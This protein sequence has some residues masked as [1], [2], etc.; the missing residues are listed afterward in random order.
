MGWLIREDRSGSSWKLGWTERTLASLTAPPLPLLAIVGIVVVLLSVS[1]YAN[2]KS[3]MQ[4]TVIGFRLFL[5]LLPLVLIF[6]AHSVTKYGTVLVVRPRTK[7]EAVS[8]GGGTPWGVVVLLV[9]LAVLISYQSYF[10]SKWWPP[11]W[12]SY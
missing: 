1:S 4:K 12:G 5:L 8:E 11:I 2:Y 10:Q 6:V 9:V 3:Q 7:H